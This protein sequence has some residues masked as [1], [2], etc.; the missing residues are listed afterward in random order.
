MRI[1]VDLGFGFV[2]GESETGEK[3]NFPSVITTRS[4]G[5]LKNVIGGIEDD[6]SI[7]YLEIGSEEKKK[8]Y[9]GDAAITHGG[10]RRWE[11][12]EQFNI[13]DI[14]VFISTA[15]GILN[16]DSEE[17]DLCVGLPMS[18]Y[19][20]KKDELRKILKSVES[21][22]WFNKNERKIKFNSIFI[23]PQG[24]GAYYSSILNKNGDTKNI[25]LANSSVGV[26]DVGY[27][28][29][30]FLVM[31]KGR[32]GITMREELSGSLEEDGMNKIYQQIQ[33]SVS[34]KFKAEIGL[35]EIEK[36]IL[37]FGSELDYFQEPINIIPYEDEEY[38][39]HAEKIASKIKIK[40]GKEE[41]RLSTI[42]ITGGGGQTL[43]YHFKEK[44]KQAE[45]QEN[46]AFSNCEGYLGIQARKMKK[47]G[48][49][50]E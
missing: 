22:I 24:A 20:Q 23:F 4:N 5:A 27:R 41:E 38:K 50:N 11:N 40:W 28:T 37:W 49:S 33:N 43:F 2:K 29:V 19:I 18:H 48:E 31:G 44:F 13:E 39:K 12:K 21:I 7:S 16:S 42:L 34:E 8:Y 6:Y 36:S 35:L 15:V 1:A 47:N 9:I 30:D 10:T 17:V 32:K 26:I 14:K 46:P 25:E 45:L 3:V